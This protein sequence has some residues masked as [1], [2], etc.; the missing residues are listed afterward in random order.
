LF[1]SDPPNLEGS[2]RLS[3]EIVV[4]PIMDT[5]RTTH[6][7]ISPPSFPPLF[8][9]S[10]FPSNAA[11]P[12]DE[13]RQAALGRRRRPPPRA[14]LSWKFGARLPRHGRL[15]CSSP[16]SSL[17]MRVYWVLL[18]GERR[19]TAGGKGPIGRPSER[20]DGRAR[21]PAGP[22]P[23]ENWRRLTSTTGCRKDR[24]RSESEWVALRR[25]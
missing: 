12:R 4:A 2:S 3:C 11:R 1:A 13:R 25:R 17:I 23:K 6:K 24:G 22:E 21:R 7:H 5:V 19:F 14:F 9:P 10:L 18:A 8:S 15:S 20:A 16:S